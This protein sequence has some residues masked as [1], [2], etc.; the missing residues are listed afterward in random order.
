MQ[1]LPPPPPPLSLSLPLVFT[2]TR[3]DHHLRLRNS[4][5]PPITLHSIPWKSCSFA[6]EFPLSRS[7]CRLELPISSYK[8]VMNRHFNFEL[9]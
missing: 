1:C 6:A 7:R 9:L 3:G 5:T 4:F 8:Q 2:G